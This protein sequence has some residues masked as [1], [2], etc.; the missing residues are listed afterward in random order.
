M[1]SLIG[2]FIGD[3]KAQEVSIDRMVALT[4][5]AELETGS[6]VTTLRYFA[7]AKRFDDLTR[8]AD[9]FRPVFERQLFEAVA[10]LELKIGRETHRM[11]VDLLGADAAPPGFRP[12]FEHERRRSADPSGRAAMP[13]ADTAARTA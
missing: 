10:P 4:A 8:A 7:E 9:L 3:Y 2:N 6:C 5:G 1:P 12:W 13:G 11:T